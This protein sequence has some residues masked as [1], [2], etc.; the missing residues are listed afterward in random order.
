MRKLIALFVLICIFTAFQG[1]SVIADEVTEVKLPIKSELSVVAE[2]DVPVD[3]LYVDDEVY[4]R[5]S[6]SQEINL[7]GIEAVISYDKEVLSLKS[8]K[9]EIEDE[10]SIRVLEE[11]DGE[12]LYAVSKKGKAET[13]NIKDNIL[14]VT[15]SAKTTGDTQVAL[16]NLKLIDNDLKYTILNDIGVIAD[17]KIPEEKSSAVVRPNRGS[18]GG[19]GGG[20]GRVSSTVKVPSGTITSAP[21]PEPTQ[22]PNQDENEVLEIAPTF[23]DLEEVDWAVGAISNL[24]EMKIINGYEGNLFKPNNIITRAESAKIIVS[25]FYKDDTYDG[26]EKFLD[27]KTNDWYYSFVMSAWKNSLVN[28]Y[29]NL[30]FKPDL[31]ITREEFA[32]ILARCIKD[33]NI[34]FKTNRLNINFTDEKDISDFAVG[35]VDMLYINSIINGNPDGSF[36]PQNTITRAEAAVMINNVI[37]AEAEYEE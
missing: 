29:E 34:K 27:V 3:K 33:K 15:F 11:K 21:S 28:G 36:M 26:E 32:T 9:A 7:Y 2:S 37:T 30:M 6:L 16:K 24:A 31:G 10:S 23:K 35:A 12:V 8:I 19:G 25:A 4:V 1:V 18:G 22:L 13:E 20:G 17:I 14:T 5:Y